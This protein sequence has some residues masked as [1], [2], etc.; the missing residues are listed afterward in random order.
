MLKKIESHLGNK[1]L[2]AMTAKGVS[3]AEVAREF[4][5]KPPTVSVD[6]LKHGRISKR[7]Y[8]HL[9]SY[10]ELPY[11]WWFGAA[12]EDKKIRDVMLHMLKMTETQKNNMVKEAFSDKKSGGTKK[13]SASQ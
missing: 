1:L 11:E 2:L 6:W 4:G 5:V 13:G 3:Q 7:H 10:F 12:G 9:V 8:S